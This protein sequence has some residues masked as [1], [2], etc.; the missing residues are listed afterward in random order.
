MDPERFLARLDEAEP[1]GPEA[2]ALIARAI[3][4]PA[5]RFDA[6][7]ID[8]PLA[9]R[10]FASRAGLQRWAVGYIEADLHRRRDPRY[11]PDLAVFHALLAV[12]GI[13]F[14]LVRAGRVAAES[15]DRDMPRFMGFFSFLASGP[16]GPGWRSCWRWPARAWSASWAPTPRSPSPATGSGPGRPARPARR[17]RGP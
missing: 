14:E 11:S 17:R 12:A 15:A 3:P 6:E 13:L 1:G 9:G 4:D 2:Q 5:D 8:R 7:R 16:P 10:R